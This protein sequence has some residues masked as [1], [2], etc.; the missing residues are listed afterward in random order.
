MRIRYL[1]ILLAALLSAIVT[2]AASD[3]VELTL[4]L[5]R[6]ALARGGEAGLEVIAHIERGWHINAHIPSESFLIPTEVK[7]AAPSEVAVEEMNYPPPDSHGFAFAKGKEL[8]V[9]EGKLGI[10]TGVKL[11]DSYRDE[12]VRFSAEMRYQ[13]CNDSTCLPPATASAELLVPVRQATV[14]AAPP[15]A[16]PAAGQFDVAAWLARRGLVMTLLLVFFLGM[17]LNLTPCV[18]PLISVTIAYFGSQT[19][20]RT[21]R[22]AVLACAYVLGITLTF[23]A[24]GVLAAL[25]GGMFGAALQR[26]AVIIFIAALLIALALSSFGVYQLRPPLWLVQRMG[27]SAPGVMGSLF[28]GA[29]MGI[30]AAP[31]VG[32]VVIALLVFVGSQQSVVLGSA[33]FLALGLGMGV[34]YIALALAAG[35]LKRL[36][37]SGEWMLWI[38]RLFGF[39]MLGLALYFLKP[40]LPLLLQKWLLPLLCAVA[41]IYLGFIDPA[42]RRMPY[43]R[44]AQW[45]VGAI[46]LIVA[47]WLA[48][49]RAA[50]STIAWQVLEPARFEEMR[51][52]RP[53]LIDFV[54]DWCI[55]CHEMENTTFRDATVLSEADRF[56]MFRADVTR[57]NGS[58][59]ALV[60]RFHVDGVPT[61]ILIDSSGQEVKRTVGYVGAEEMIANMQAVR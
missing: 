2:H 26:P 19:H 49:P 3:K 9:Y 23:A 61:V 1:S 13:A 16:R 8:L 20:H 28:M 58:T 36:P 47:G 30:V 48:S 39:L 43:F 42:G 59:A 15:P 25:S 37:R 18:Y 51:H 22:T 10:T 53:A 32:P 27:G 14:G 6:E 34:P 11:S 56:A 55:P 46:A 54:A 57:E 40:L 44:T 31:C 35:S 45:S 12:S 33:L 52:G 50:E 21:A 24:V 5:D 4:E 60:E 7:V 29:T 41:G 38:E 17:G